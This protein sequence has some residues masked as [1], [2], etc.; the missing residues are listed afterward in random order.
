MVSKLELFA[1]FLHVHGFPKFIS[2]HLSDK[3][4]LDAWENSNEALKLT[5]GSQQLFYSVLRDNH[6][7]RRRGLVCQTWKR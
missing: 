2:Y 1:F 6:W 7:V 4:S 5:G 3:A